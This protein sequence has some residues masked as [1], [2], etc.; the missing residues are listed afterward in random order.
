[1]E[2]RTRPI[3]QPTCDEPEA[4][5]RNLAT[6]IITW[7][8]GHTEGGVVE[9]Y[10]RLCPEHAIEARRSPRFIREEPW[11]FEADPLVPNDVTEEVIPEGE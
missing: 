6:T 4:N 5:C 7:R 10:Q 2:E 3:S 9:Y 11:S 1:M 8:A